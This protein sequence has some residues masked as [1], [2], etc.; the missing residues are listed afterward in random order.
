MPRKKLKHPDEEITNITSLPTTILSYIAS[1]FLTLKAAAALACTCSYINTSL[2]AQ[3]LQRP[4]VCL[5]GHTIINHVSSIDKLFDR[6][7]LAMD[8][9]EVVTVDPSELEGHV[10]VDHFETTVAGRRIPLQGTLVPANTSLV[11]C[12]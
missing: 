12:G 7:T 3:H 10:D 6:K 4:V 9:L 8:E 1:E 2:D 5:C 11:I